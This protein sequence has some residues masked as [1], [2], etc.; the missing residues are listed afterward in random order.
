MVQKERKS[1][2]GI[3]GRKLLD[4]IGN[5]VKNE[6]LLVGRDAFFN[7][8]RENRLLI[9]RYRAKKKTTDSRHRFHKYPNLI[10]DL[11]PVRPHQLW[12]SDITYIETTEGYLYLSLVTDAYSRKIIG[13]NISP[14]LEAEG[15]VSTLSMAITQLPKEPVEL[16]HHS[17]RGIQYCCKKYVSKLNAFRIGIGMTENGDPLENAIA[18]RV[19]GIL[20]TE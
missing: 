20:K 17:D 10:R 18:E 15:A 8:L 5:A 14:K 11:V 7:L 6:Q 16:I 13:W 9:R 4:V 2:P 1:L 12:V 3:G 19:N